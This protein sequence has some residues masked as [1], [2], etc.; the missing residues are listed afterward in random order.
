MTVDEMV[1]EL[2]K[3]VKTPDDEIMILPFGNAKPNDVIRWI[4]N[5]SN[6]DFD[7]L[8]HTPIIAQAKIHYCNIRKFN[9]GE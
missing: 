7:V 8:L 5:L 4:I 1:H 9:K 2:H 6:E 3:V